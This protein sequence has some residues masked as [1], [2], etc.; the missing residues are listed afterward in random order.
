MTNK[1]LLTTNEFYEKYKQY[2]FARLHSV[3]PSH[4]PMFDSKFLEV[5]FNGNTMDGGA[6]H[7]PEKFS[8]GLWAIP[9]TGSWYA[10]HDGEKFM[11]NF[12]HGIKFFYEDKEYEIPK[13][14]ISWIDGE[15]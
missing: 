6:F 7:K 4:I 12:S 13:T 2:H 11:D 5:N 3:P 10:F 15:D 14:G 8:Y 1:K 9:A